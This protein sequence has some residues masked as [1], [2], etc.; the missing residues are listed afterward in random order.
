MQN[1]SSFSAARVVENSISA[2][3]QPWR[4]LSPFC[5][6][7]V[8]PSVSAA[9]QIF[10]HAGVSRFLQPSRIFHDLVNPIFANLWQSCHIPALLSISFSVY[11]FF[12]I[13]T[14]KCSVFTRPPSS[15]ILS[16]CPNHRN[17]CS[18]RNSSNLSTPVI[19]HMLFPNITFEIF[20]MLI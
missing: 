7:N 10:S 20:S 1:N 11:L 6:R 2:S 14:S 9:Q 8:F 12:V 16:T 13:L 18:L 4:R 3:Y 19:L 17:L 15:S 5:F